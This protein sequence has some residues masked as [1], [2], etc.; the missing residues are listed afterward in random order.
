MLGLLTGYFLF[1]LA[2]LF[3][4]D[5][6]GGDESNC[7][8]GQITFQVVDS[9]PDDHSGDDEEED[10]TEGDGNDDEDS[11]E[12]SDS[13]GDSEDDD[14]DSDDDDGGDSEDD[15]GDSDEGS[16]SGG[17]SEDDDGDSDDDDGGDS[18]DDDGDSDN[19]DGGDSE[20]DDGD[21]DDDD[22]G[23]SE[24]DDGDSDDDSGNDRRGRSG[25]SIGLSVGYPVILRDA[26]SGE[27]VFSGHTDSTGHFFSDPLPFGSYLLELCH[28]DPI[29]FEILHCD[30]TD[31][32]P[33]AVTN[34]AG[35]LSGRLLDRNHQPRL[36]TEVALLTSDR[37]PIM[38]TLTST[39]GSFAFP[40]LATGDYQLA[41]SHCGG[42][43]YLPVSISPCWETQVDFIADPSRWIAGFVINDLNRNGLDDGEPPL[44]GVPIS[45]FQGQTRIGET[46]TEPDGSFH[47]CV[48][49]GM[50]R[51]ESRTPEGYES[52]GDSDPINDD[53]IEISVETG[54]A[55]DL[56]FLD[57]LPPPAPEPVEVNERF[58]IRGRVINDLNWTGWDDGEPGLPDVRIVL[59]ATDG[60]RRNTLTDSAG[61][62][63]FENLRPG[64]YELIETDPAGFLS[65][66]DSE[67]PNDNRIALFL[68]TTDIRQAN[69]FDAA[70]DLPAELPPDG[71][72]RFLLGG[73]VLHDRN[74]NGQA[75]AAEAGLEGVQVQLLRPL[76]QLLAETFT[77]ANGYYA[78]GNLLGG[79]YVIRE[80]DPP[81]FASHS[82]SG[83][84]NDN[85]ISVSLVD[86]HRLDNH[87][88][89]L[90]PGTD[91]S[92]KPSRFAIGGRVLNDSS[93]GGLQDVTVELRNA[94]GTA[95][96]VDQTD[97]SGHFH[98]ADLPSAW[99]I[100]VEFDPP[101][102]RS[103]SDS[104]APNDNLVP[105]QLTDRNV[106]NVEFRD[107]PPAGQTHAIRGR[108]LHDLNG[109]G[110]EDPLEPPIQFVPLQ[111]FSS[112]G[113][114]LAVQ[115]TN[116]RG[117]YEFSRLSAGEYQVL[118][119]D[120]PR[121][122]S[123]ADTDGLNDNLITVQLVDT[124][125]EGHNFL[126][127]RPQ[128]VQDP[129]SDCLHLSGR[130]AE[131]ILTGPG[132]S[133]ARLDLFN[134][135]GL[136]IASTLSDGL[137]EYEFP[138]LP[139][140]S[141]AIVE[142]DP[143]G[144][145]SSANRIDLE[146]TD[147]SI[148]N[149]NFVDSRLQLTIRGQILEDAGTESAPSQ[150][151]LPDVQVQL[152]DADGH[153]L[154]VTY[155][156]SN[157]LY[158]FSDLAPGHYIVTTEKPEGFASTADADGVNDC[159]IAV[160]LVDADS[161]NNNFHFERVFE[162]S[163]RLIQ[164]LDFDGRPDPGE[165]GTPEGEILLLDELGNPIA[166]TTPAPDGSYSFENVPEGEYI[167]R[168]KPPE[169]SLPTGDADGNNDGRIPVQVR[170]ASVESQDF[171]TLPA[172]QIPAIQPQ[173]QLEV[174]VEPVG[175]PELRSVYL[176]MTR[177]SLVTYSYQIC[178]PGN[179]D[180]A[181]VILRSESLGFELPIG[182]MASGE[183][184]EY[185][186]TEQAGRVA[187]VD[188]EVVGRAVRRSGEAWPE[189][190]M[191]G[192][193]KPKSHRAVK[194]ELSDAEADL[195]RATGFL[196]FRGLVWEDLSGDGQPG[197]EN[198]T[199]LGVNGVTLDLYQRRQNGWE[200]MAQD[201][202][203]PHEGQSGTYIFGGLAPGDYRI[204][205]A[206]EGLPANFSVDRSQLQVDVK[207][208]PAGG[209]DDLYATHG[210]LAERAT[211][212]LQRLEIINL[213][214]GALVFWQMA[215]ESGTLGYIL[216]RAIADGRWEAVRP[217]LIPVQPRAAGG[218][219]C[220]L[221]EAGTPDSIYRLER[222]TIHLETKWLGESKVKVGKNRTR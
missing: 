40:S 80:I 38:Y 64:A 76:G 25:S 214:K 222:L 122:G 36:H 119:A 23:D 154:A 63:I 159:S 100:L 43:L 88:Y 1:S 180:L 164:D 213:E 49:P 220:I 207:L 59:Q 158:R 94:N 216:S 77:D 21:S 137:G 114:L 149:L 151:A 53:R 153:P 163:G 204:R 210:L 97:T 62:F 212:R 30:P 60:S 201:T 42:E 188:A 146:L 72:P 7:H 99:Y 27:I 179:S 29:P 41:V 111:L 55:L 82:D 109:N 56:L 51:V 73:R 144:F 127:L 84:L 209:G 92:G 78:F 202:T 54:D 150:L 48:S 11:D 39:N 3:G 166:S 152:W 87:F 182:K 192:D 196:I 167:L 141:Y 89:D 175:Q 90:L 162:I 85:L 34:P 44:P 31:L 47:F 117:E 135:S 32:G 75:D 81:G 110:I 221:D 112:A 198:L 125:S 157:G 116:A 15:D 74:L 115:F 33:I 106:T 108:V 165:T 181:D 132:L 102:H 130:V 37:Q 143:P 215:D 57:A 8:T 45:L 193:E 58:S 186:L 169:G 147:Q 91:A 96:A 68:T 156:N 183:C 18:E 120:P 9:L 128:A 19:D 136:L 35:D 20:D 219:Y 203:R 211:D 205:I 160:S 194:V 46:W 86:H 131:E 79:D 177:G 187:T 52:I 178:N 103:V 70:I 126:D 105:V 140:G 172:H 217:D 67:G 61:H 129:S 50:Y 14:G 185:T 176:R 118:E 121:F 93:G 101:G 26:D 22:G 139:A 28:L 107:R 138:C 6:S 189:V 95:V 195:R 173:L 133:S 65:T 145:F 83:G 104:S 170:G 218:E 206:E 191:A 142:T 184:L 17:D 98:F 174:N 199:S 208:N 113:E 71:M 134:G 69:F 10:G 4:M 124:D 190:A 123:T 13:G 66:G 197:D 24:D 148:V 16:D 200:W 168:G 12:G 171:Y 155:S 5:I 161:D 2:L